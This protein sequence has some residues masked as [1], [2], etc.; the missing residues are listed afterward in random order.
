MKITGSGPAAGTSQRRRVANGAG[1]GAGGSFAAQVGG[2]ASMIAGIAP[3]TPLAALDGVLAVQE[4]EDPTA[5]RRRATR[6]GHSLLDELRALQLGLVDGWV[7]EGTL[8]RLSGL[9]DS[10]RPDAGDPQLTAVLDAIELR[11]AV[12]LAKLRRGP[13]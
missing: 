5:E 6:H 3:A 11:A 10:L 7:S 4:V 1:D 9:V 13:D 12:E 8:R 2:R